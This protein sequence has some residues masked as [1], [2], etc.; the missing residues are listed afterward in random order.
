MVTPSILRNELKLFH[1]EKSE[2]PWIAL[3]EQAVERADYP[4]LVDTTGTS[5]AEF[6][7]KI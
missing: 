7:A 1:A 5:K 3:V 2:D 6:A 4:E